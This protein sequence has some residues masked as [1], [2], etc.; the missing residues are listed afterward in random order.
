MSQERILDRQVVRRNPFAQVTDSFFLFPQKVHH[1]HL[2]IR[3]CLLNLIHL[4]SVIHTVVR[5][6]QRR[7]LIGFALKPQ[8]RIRLGQNLVNVRSQNVALG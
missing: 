4:V 3:D 1:L 8:L 5:D 7:V 2:L 6:F